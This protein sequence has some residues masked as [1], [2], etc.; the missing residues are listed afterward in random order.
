[1]SVRLKKLVGTL[2]IAAFLTIYCLAVM[3]LAVALLP[4]TSGWTQLL[5]YTVFGL[6]WVLPVGGLIKWMHATAQS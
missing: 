6:I 4:G 1:M 2:I 3:L 5:F